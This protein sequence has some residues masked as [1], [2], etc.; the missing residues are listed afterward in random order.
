M[1]CDQCANELTVTVDAIVYGDAVQCCSS[2]CVE[3]LTRLWAPTVRRTTH[4][5]ALGAAWALVGVLSVLLWLV[6]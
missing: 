1:W 5:K 4:A 3:R 2:Q 6:P